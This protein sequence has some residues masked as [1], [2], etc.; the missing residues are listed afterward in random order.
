MKDLNISSN[1]IIIDQV[2]CIIL[3]LLLITLLPRNRVKLK[4]LV[5]LKLS[6]EFS[7]CVVF[8]TC[9]KLNIEGAIRMP[10]MYFEGLDCL[11]HLVRFIMV[12]IGTACII[13]VKLFIVIK[14]I[15]PSFIVTDSTAKYIVIIRSILIIITIIIIGLKNINYIAR[16]I[17]IRNFHL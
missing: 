12:L 11:N 3:A 10:N 15:R 2:K 17:K 8:R 5:G 4:S 9:L 7:M 16:H 6:L 13:T 1:V 14:D